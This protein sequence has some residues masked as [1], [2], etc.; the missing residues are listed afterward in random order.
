MRNFICAVILLF[1]VITI[2]SVNSFF[3]LDIFDDM[4]NLIERGDANAAIELWE[5]KEKYVSL[6][7]RDSEIDLINRDILYYRLYGESKENEKRLIFTINELKESEKI[8][9]FNV[10]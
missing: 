10:F 5:R 6:F 9:F 8:N 3:I 2:A 4:L 7:I 1:A